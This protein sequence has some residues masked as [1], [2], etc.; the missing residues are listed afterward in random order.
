MFLRFSLIA[1]LIAAPLS[2]AFAQG[3]S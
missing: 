3:T 2:A 1:V